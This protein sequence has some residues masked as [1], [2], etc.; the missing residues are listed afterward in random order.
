MA[1]QVMDKAEFP[2]VIGPDAS[3]KGE[4]SFEKGVKLLGKFE[5]QI[6]TKGTL[7]VASGS[8]LKAGVQAG[9]IAV[10]GE[11][12][13]NLAATERIELRSSAKL[14]GD[15]RTARLVVADGATFFGS[16]QVGADAA[17]QSG[18]KLTAAPVKIESP[19][20][21]TEPMLATAKR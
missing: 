18:T 8:S 20:R 2:T 13:G 21:R 15:I 10:E 9:G 12:E 17:K 4:L 14:H 6:T 7:L 19:D 16:V 11:V 1:D 3:F 5:G